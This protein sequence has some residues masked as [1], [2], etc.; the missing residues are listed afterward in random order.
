MNDFDTFVGASNIGSF[1][2]QV[3]GLRHLLKGEDL[4][5]IR[6]QA[7]DEL[8]QAF[9]IIDVYQDDVNN[10]FLFTLVERYTW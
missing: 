5:G 3:V 7:R 10:D 6:E 1:L 9:D 8:C 2:F 4:A